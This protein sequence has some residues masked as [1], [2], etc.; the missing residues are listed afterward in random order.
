MVS[1]WN[2]VQSVSPNGLGVLHISLTNP[3]AEFSSGV[4]WDYSLGYGDKMVG[5]EQHP[6]GSGGNDFLK[7]ILLINSQIEPYQTQM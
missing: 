2:K 6:V 5:D 4:A 7:S 1:L 3:Q